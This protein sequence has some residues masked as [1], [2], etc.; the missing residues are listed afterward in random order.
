MKI[1]LAPLPRPS[2]AHHHAAEKIA[3]QQK[4]GEAP[5]G[6]CQPLPRDI[7]QTSLLADAWGAAARCFGRA[8]L[9]A[10]RPR[11]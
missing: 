2:S 8:R 10:L 6:A 9:P 11:L 3:S 1:V 5:K 4:G 7:K